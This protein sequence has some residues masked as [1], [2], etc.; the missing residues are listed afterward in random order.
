MVQD[1]RG[2]PT[3]GYYRRLPKDAAAIIS[4]AT[5]KA[6]SFGVPTAYHFARATYRTCVARSLICIVRIVTPRKPRD[7]ATCRQESP[8]RACSVTRNRFADKLHRAC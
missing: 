3:P 6:V 4:F 7:T 1:G 2:D 5:E 8:R